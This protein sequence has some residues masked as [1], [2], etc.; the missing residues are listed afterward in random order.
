M[1]PQTRMRRLRYGK[2]KDMVRENT[3]TVNDLIYPFFVDET[4]DKKIDVASMPG[5]SRWPL[6]QAVDAAREAYDLGIPAVLIFGIPKTKDAEGKSAYGDD[7]VV[8]AA[9]RAIKAEFGKDLIV[10]TDLCMCEYTDHGHCGIVNFETHDVVNDLTL[11]ILGKIAV[12]H[13]KAGADIV[14]PS[15]MMDGMIEAIRSALDENGFENT[16]IMSY[17]SKYAS[18]FYG[19]FRDA[20][21]SGFCFGDRSEYQMDPANSDE[22]IRETELDVL[23][24]ADM[25][26]VKPGMPYLDIVYRIKQ[27]FGLPLAVYQVS[28]EYAMIKAAAAN[29]WL[30]EEKA[31]YEAC[32]SMKR[33]GADMIITYYAKE[34]AMILAEK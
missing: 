11:P 21:D 25:L 24:G 14:A 7:D 17:S 30:D 32:L 12:S 2:L 20:A 23:E 9:V 18:V 19:P 8:Q 31:F 33:A 26:M 13:A 16:P 28:G 27:E 29:G 4:T 22:A 15:G 5:V 10:I 1:F 3:L 6:A 34:L